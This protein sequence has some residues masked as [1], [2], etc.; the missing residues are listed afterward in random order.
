MGPI[1]ASRLSR[2]GWR[3]IYLLLPEI[4]SYACRYPPFLIHVNCIPVIPFL[5]AA[6]LLAI[7]FSSLFSNFSVGER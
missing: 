7:P 2:I 5:G 4:F 6:Y 1:W 3:L